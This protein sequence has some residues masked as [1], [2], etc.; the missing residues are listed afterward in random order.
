MLAFFNCLNNGRRNWNALRPRGPSLF[1]SAGKGSKRGRFARHVG[2]GKMKL[3]SNPFGEP[4]QTQPLTRL[5][6]H[7]KVRF[8][9]T[10]KNSLTSHADSCCGR[11]LGPSTAHRI[12]T[13]KY[14]QDSPF[15]SPPSLKPPTSKYDRLWFQFYEKSRAASM[16]KRALGESLHGGNRR[17]T[18]CSKI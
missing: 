8:C 17:E 11:C 5:Q 4:F 6:T 2:S 14:C 9:P 1:R 15:Q 18:D 10:G 13:R 7:G 12:K 16:P 3:R